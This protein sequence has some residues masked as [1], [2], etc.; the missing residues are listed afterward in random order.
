MTRG[1]NF[2]AKLSLMA[3]EYFSARVIDILEIRTS[4]LGEVFIYGEKN[5][6]WSILKIPALAL[7]EDMDSP[8][9]HF[10]V[11]SIKNPFNDKLSFFTFTHS[12][13]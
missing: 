1:P 9:G 11:E 2:G 12:F 10:R 6:R 4:I 3:F 13:L 7:G 5:M 8:R